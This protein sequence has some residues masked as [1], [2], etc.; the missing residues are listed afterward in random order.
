MPR[1]YHFDDSTSVKPPPFL[2]SFIR[3]EVIVGPTLMTIGGFV[4]RVRQDYSFVVVG[5]TLTLLG[6]YRLRSLYGPSRKKA[7]IENDRLLTKFEHS[8]DANYSVVR[9]YSLP[10][11][12]EE[13]PYLVLGPSGVFSIR[14]WDHSGE[15]RVENEEW[16]VTSEDRAERFQ[17]PMKDLK[18]DVQLLGSFLRRNNEKGVPVEGR[19]VLMK[20]TTNG[21][22]WEDERVVYLRNLPESLVPE[23]DESPLDWED[24][25]RLEEVLGLSR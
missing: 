7:L 15:I 1:V 22:T 25:D 8:L 3:F 21:T 24:V 9:N 17:S 19:L 10:E 18:R 23:T 13:I 20:N 2:R 4:L 5:L 12:E 16:V 14:R 11:A 6:L